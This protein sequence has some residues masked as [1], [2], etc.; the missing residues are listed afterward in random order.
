MAHGFKP[1]GFDM[2]RL[3]DYTAFQF[4]PETNTNY[5]AGIKSGLFDNHLDLNFSAFYTDYKN[6]QTLAFD[7]LNLVTTN[8]GKFTTKGFELEA[9]ARPLKGLNLTAALGYV[10]AHYVSFPNG[11]CPTGVTGSCNLDGKSLDGTPH[12]TF[13]TSAQYD[14]EVAPNFDAFVR[15]DAAFKSRIFYQQSLD[16]NAVQ[17]GYGLLNVRVGMNF[18]DRWEADIFADNATQTKY[19]SFIYPS[20]LAT[21]LFVG[22]V[23]APRIIGVRVQKSF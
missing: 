23:G 11:Q 8:A 22:Y 13:S 3:S 16:P 18:A 10:D 21:G 12:W 17:N 7:G 1:G 6:F 5:E 19:M 14:W 4:R 9:I 2:T 20:P 15:M